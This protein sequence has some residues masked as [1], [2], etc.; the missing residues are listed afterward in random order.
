MEVIIGAGLP[1]AFVATLVF[2][3]VT[4]TTSDE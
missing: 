2:L 3:I 4:V 1:I